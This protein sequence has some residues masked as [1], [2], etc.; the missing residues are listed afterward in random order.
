MRKSS[1]TF[2]KLKKKIGKH[3]KKQK[4]QH[5]YQ[6]GYMVVIQW[7]QFGSGL[8]LRSKL[9]G[10]YEVTKVKSHERYDV[11]KVGIHE[12]PIKTSTAPNHM[13]P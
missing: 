10:R 11:K 3:D 5:I 4:R 12:G 13:K 9:H 7:T 8:K 1:K 6:R 2:K